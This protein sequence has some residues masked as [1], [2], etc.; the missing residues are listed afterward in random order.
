MKVEEGVMQ[1][2]IIYY[3]LPNLPKTLC[4]FMVQNDFSLQMEQKIFPE[5]FFGFPETKVPFEVKIGLP[6]R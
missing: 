2:A 6:F 5:H 4:S 3:N 1:V